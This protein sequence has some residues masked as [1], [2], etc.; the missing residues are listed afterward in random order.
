MMDIFRRQSSNSNKTNN[1]IKNSHGDNGLQKDLFTKCQQSNKSQDIIVTHILSAGQPVEQQ[2]CNTLT[3]IERDE[4]ENGDLNS[5]SDLLLQN[6]FSFLIA[7]GMLKPSP[8]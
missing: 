8:F 1:M 5:D 7:K 3:F 4:Q 2:N 6:N